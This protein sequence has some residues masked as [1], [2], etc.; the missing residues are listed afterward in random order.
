[1]SV[2]SFG[3]PLCS[4]S[5]EL[6]LLGGDDAPR[7]RANG[8]CV[9]VSGMDEKWKITN[10]GVYIRPSGYVYTSPGGRALGRRHVSDYRAATVVPYVPCESTRG[11]W[12]SVC[13]DCGRMLPKP[14][15]KHAVA[16]GHRLGSL[17]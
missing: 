6:A 5:P 3:S 8:K 15:P 12:G 11:T 13:P 4:L 7:A 9:R 2:P 10:D 16:S 1:M 14:A 17:V